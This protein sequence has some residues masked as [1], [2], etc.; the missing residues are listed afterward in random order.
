MLDSSSHK[1][2]NFLRSSS[3]SRKVRNMARRYFDYEALILV[4]YCVSS[5]VFIG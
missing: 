2:N 3:S 5:L 1:G 4:L